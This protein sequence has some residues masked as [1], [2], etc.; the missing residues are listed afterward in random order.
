[1]GATKPCAFEFDPNKVTWVLKGSAVF[2]A[3]PLASV[4][5]TSNTTTTIVAGRQ[6]PSALERRTT[7]TTNSPESHGAPSMAV[8]LEEFV[9]T[10]GTDEA[11]RL[12]MT[13]IP[14]NRARGFYPEYF[15]AKRLPLLKSEL[16]MDPRRY[17][18]VLQRAAAA[19]TTAAAATAM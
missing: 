7:T 6:S 15:H 13:L 12:V 18:R 17:H 9:D 11:F 10:L 19:T 3:S 5:A 4:K 8:A 1:M 14:A 2:N 16:K